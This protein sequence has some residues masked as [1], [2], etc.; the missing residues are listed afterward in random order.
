[1]AGSLLFVVCIFGR[2]FWFG[3]CL[4]FDFPFYPLVVVWC[5]LLRGP[6]PSGFEEVWGVLVALGVLMLV[7]CTMLFALLYILFSNTW[8]PI[9]PLLAYIYIYYKNLQKLP[10]PNPWMKSQNSLVHS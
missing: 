10:L 9:P 7:F 6:P 2:V 1:M 4:D 5:E 3:L 8:R